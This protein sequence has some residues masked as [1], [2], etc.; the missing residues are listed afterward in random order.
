MME[1]KNQWKTKFDAHLDPEIDLRDR[2][3]LLKKL[4]KKQIDM[5]DHGEN[6]GMVS[7]K[8]S[9][10]QIFGHEHYKHKFYYLNDLLFSPKNRF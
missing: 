9:N 5:L 1:S 4:T 2:E 8:M 7:N 3:T 10:S 6:I